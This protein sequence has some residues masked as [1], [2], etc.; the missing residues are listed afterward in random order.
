[1]KDNYLNWSICFFNRRATFHVWG[2]WS[3]VTHVIWTPVYWHRFITAENMHLGIPLI[4]PCIRSINLYNLYVIL[5]CWKWWL[6]CKQWVSAVWILCDLKRHFHDGSKERRLKSNSRVTCLG[7]F[8]IIRLHFCLIRIT[9][10]IAM[11]VCQGISDS[12][13][14]PAGSKIEMEMGYVP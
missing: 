4:F 7:G 2:L 3:N 14:S 13:S 10:L 12:F 1:M 6:F 11:S 8:M 5:I 9:T